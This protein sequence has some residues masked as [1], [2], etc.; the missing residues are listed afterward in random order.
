MV[1]RICSNGMNSAI[2]T[3]AGPGLCLLF[4]HATVVHRLVLQWFCVLVQ[5]ENESCGLDERS[6]FGFVF[7]GSIEVNIVLDP[8][9]VSR[10]WLFVSFFFS[11]SDIFVAK[12]RTILRSD[13]SRLGRV[14]GVCFQKK[15][16]KMRQAWC[17]KC[18]E[19]APEMVWC[20]LAS[21]CRRFLH[22]HVIRKE[23]VTHWLQQKARCRPANILTPHS[24]KL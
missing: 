12:C 17:L 15:A 10:T 23:Y 24:D 18:G 2:S 11:A 6:S 14:C 4:L 20:G 16:G 9:P 13:T 22:R 5:I 7:S 8:V 3:S 19:E 21:F 1:K